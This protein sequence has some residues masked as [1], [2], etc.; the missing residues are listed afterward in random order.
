ML[1]VDRSK[2]FD[3]SLL[4]PLVIKIVVL[5]AELYQVVTKHRGQVFAGPDLILLL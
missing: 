4:V 3:W 2:E 1:E 5:F